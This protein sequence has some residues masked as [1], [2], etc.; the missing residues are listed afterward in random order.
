MKHIKFFRWKT[1]EWR[2]RMLYGF[3]NVLEGMVTL[4]TFGFLGWGG[5]STEILFKSEKINLEK[6]L[7][8]QPSERMDVV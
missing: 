1:H 6:R 5:W 2:Y 4:L 8:R 3:A 7:T